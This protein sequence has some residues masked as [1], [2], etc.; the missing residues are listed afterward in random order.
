M[1][2]AIGI[3]LLLVGAVA[4]AAPPVSFPDV[5]DFSMSTADLVEIV[6]SEAYDRI[7]PDKYLI[8]QGSVAST[9]ILDPSVETYQALVELVSSEWLSLSE[10]AV[11]KVFVLLE[12]PDFSDRVV[13]RLPRDPGPEIILTN[14]QLMVVGEFIGVAEDTDGSTVPVVSA[15]AL[16]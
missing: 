8:L 12:G 1:R 15:V 2:R 7:D 13:E 11:Y 9:M 4:F 10:I 3:L 14:S 6:R 5:V 16:R